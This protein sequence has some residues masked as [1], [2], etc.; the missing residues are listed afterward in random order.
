[1]SEGTGPRN[2]L[3][4]RGDALLRTAAGIDPGF[5]EPADSQTVVVAE[6]AGELPFLA[7]RYGDTVY[8]LDHRR[9]LYRIDQQQGRS[10]WHVFTANGTVRLDD[11]GPFD[12][13][14]N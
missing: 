2:D 14:L 3:D 7:A 8:A 1:M 6:H 10:V 5:R 11:T 13:Q 12:I 9:R 4:D